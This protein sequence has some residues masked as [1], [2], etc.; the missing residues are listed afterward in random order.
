MPWYINFGNDC[1]ITF[2]G[3]FHYFL[4]IFLRIKTSHSSFLACFGWFTVAKMTRT[5]N[6]KCSNFGE[7]WER[8][9]FNSPAFIIG[10]MPVKSIEFRASNIINVLFNFGFCKEISAD[11]EHN[12]PPSKTW[13]VS[14]FYG[15]NYPI[16]IC[17]CL[18]F[19][20]FW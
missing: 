5:R 20:L 15:R 18:A 4:N 13:I 14:D 1:N 6:T 2:L 12:S 9:Y 17:S 11:I 7:F 3:I 16:C 19:N 10:Q 8:F